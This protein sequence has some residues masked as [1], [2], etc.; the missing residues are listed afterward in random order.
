VPERYAI[1]SCHVER[2][3]D[4]R[5]W[6]AFSRL[7]ARRPGG[8]EIAALVRPPDPAAGEDEAVWLA[9]AQEAATRG[10]IGHHTHWGG[11]TQARPTGG[12]PAE[13]VRS[14]AAWFREQG[15]EPR[16]FCGGGWYMDESVAGAL[17]E[18]GYVD[19]TATA[20]RPGYLAPGAA[21]LSLGAPARLRLNGTTLLELPATHSLGMAVRSVLGPLPEYVHVYFHDTDLLHTGRRRALQAALALLGR[22]SEPARLD[23][24]DAEDE[25]EFRAAVSGV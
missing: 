6:A 3:L 22:R 2:L 11:A 21:R 18:L 9:R 23:R 8:F 4:D 7:Q 12:D 24:L 13:R 17:A 1:V 16:L 19:C 14:E 5:V 15:L 25:L 10:P 20:F